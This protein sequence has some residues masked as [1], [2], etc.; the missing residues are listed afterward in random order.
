MAN[1]TLSDVH[2]NRTLTN[3]LIA[4]MQSEQ[5]FVADR[6][7]PNVPVA[8]QA[9]SYFMYD[10]SDWWRA[11]MRK[12]A[13]GTESAGAGWRM[14]SDTYFAHVWAL[15]VDIS[16]QTRA[17]ADEPINLD[18]DATRFLAGQ[19]LITREIEWASNFFTTGVWTGSSTGTD[20]LGAST[21]TTDQ[22]LRWNNANSTPIED[23]RSEATAMQLKTGFRP[24]KLILGQYVADALMDH[25]DIVD[26]IKYSSSN[27][28]PT[29]VS[30]SVLAQ[31][32]QVEEVLIASGIQVTSAEN[33]TFETSMTTAFIAGKHALLL[34]SPRNANTY[35]PSA[36]YTFSWTGLLG[37]GA[38][39]GRI[40]TIRAELIKSDR[41]EAEMAFV[42]KLTGAQ[43]GVFFSGIVD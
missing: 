42:H 6:A 30:L 2:V 17:N 13:P 21:A 43:L 16:D 8:K 7:F 1:P 33:P 22:P 29:M 36:G 38:L 27:N 35:Q 10:R 15:H 40:S 25:P 23:I 5:N 26:R 28:A 32:F 4:Y 11:S 31:L 18:T 19:A 39:G 14:S 37:A 12:R 9:D 34:Y 3:V 24:N 20:I 41:V